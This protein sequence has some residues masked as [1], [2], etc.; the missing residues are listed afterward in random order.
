MEIINA[1]LVLQQRVDMLVLSECDK[2]TLAMASLAAEALAKQL[3]TL[4]DELRSCPGTYWREG[5]VPH[6]PGSASQMHKGY[7]GPPRDSGE[8]VAI[9]D[10]CGAKLYRDQ[11]KKKQRK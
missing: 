9:C 7:R 4:N 1:I 2:D 5:A 8:G 10:N 3:L 11:K 6:V